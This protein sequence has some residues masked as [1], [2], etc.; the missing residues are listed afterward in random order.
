[1]IIRPKATPPLP[2]MSIAEIPDQ[3]ADLAG[4][5]VPILPESAQLDP[6]LGDGVANWLDEY[7]ALSRLWS[8][9]AYD[10]F[11]IACALWMLSTVAARRVVCHFG[12][13]RYTNL[14]IALVARSSLSNRPPPDH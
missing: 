5:E 3:V 9:R 13:S 11:H 4:V 10:D 7:V 8:P 6:E 12:G 14:Y 2:H 1:M